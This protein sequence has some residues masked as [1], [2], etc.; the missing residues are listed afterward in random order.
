[1]SSNKLNLVSLKQGDVELETA[2]ET[3]GLQ[4][5]FGLDSVRLSDWTPTIRSVQSDLM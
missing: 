5:C 4:F 1:M 2:L 3:G